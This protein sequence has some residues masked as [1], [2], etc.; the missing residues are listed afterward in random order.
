MQVE[1]VL[2]RLLDAGYEVCSRKVDQIY[3]VRLSR[4]DGPV[5]MTEANDVNEALYQAAELAGFNLNDF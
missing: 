1:L 5:R 2:G 3:Q 4:Q